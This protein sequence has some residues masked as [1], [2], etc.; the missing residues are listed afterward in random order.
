M[1]WT[2]SHT[3]GTGEDR[4]TETEHYSATENLFEQAIIVHGEG[5]TLLTKNES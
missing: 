5:M 4:K 1:H 2:E 3:T